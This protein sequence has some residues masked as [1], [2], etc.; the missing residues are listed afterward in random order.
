MLSN[1]TVP[2][3][4]DP[5]LF[6]PAAWIVNSRVSLQNIPVRRGK[7][8]IAV[9]VKNLTD[10]DLPVFL[11]NFG[12]LAWTNYESARTFGVDAISSF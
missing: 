9:W 8:E 7:M 11:I 2:V 12:N 5:V 1:A 6:A 10:N 3:V 4:Y